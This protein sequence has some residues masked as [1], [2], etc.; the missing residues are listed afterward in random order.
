MT[1]TM[2]VTAWLATAAEGCLYDVLFAESPRFLRFL[3]L[4]GALSESYED[5]LV[6]VS[7]DESQSGEFDCDEHACGR[8]PSKSAL[9]DLDRNDRDELAREGERP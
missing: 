4:R 8:D 3:R 6:V 5:S 2:T 1:V 7:L 9:G